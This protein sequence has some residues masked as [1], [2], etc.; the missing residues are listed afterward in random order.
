MIETRVIESLDRWGKTNPWAAKVARQKL[1]EYQ[2]RT[3][4]DV[5]RRV[6]PQA[7]RRAAA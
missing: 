4:R 3:N 5:I 2:A 7:D 6:T 1:R